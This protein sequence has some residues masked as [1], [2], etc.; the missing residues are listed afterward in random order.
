MSTPKKPRVQG[1]GAYCA[2]CRGHR[3]HAVCCTRSPSGVVTRNMTC[4]GCETVTRI[5]LCCP[6]CGDCRLRVDW[7][8]HRAGSTVRRKSCLNCGHRMRT[9]ETFEAGNG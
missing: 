2:E 6:K 1:K 5:G 4:G 9:R 8:R 3:L 7:T